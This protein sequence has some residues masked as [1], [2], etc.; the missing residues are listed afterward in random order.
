MPLQI[1]DLV[2]P[3][4]SEHLLKI[5][6]RPNPPKLSLRIKNGNTKYH[7][8]VLDIDA[9]GLKG[10]ENMRNANDGVVYFGTLKH[11]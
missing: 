7:N 1:N 10:P 2:V 8:K 11:S 5:A 3:A 9:L 4:K 6:N